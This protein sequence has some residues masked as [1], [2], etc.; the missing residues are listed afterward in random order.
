[1]KEIQITKHNRNTLMREIE[2]H[3]MLKNENVIGLIEFEVSAEECLLILELAE[4]NLHQFIAKHHL[5]CNF[6]LVELL[7][8]IC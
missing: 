5:N 4:L 3:S 6:E 7:A 2:I 1:M 8:K